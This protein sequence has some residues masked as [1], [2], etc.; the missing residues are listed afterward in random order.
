MQR[1]WSWLQ[2]RR[3][4]PLGPIY[5][6]CKPRD[7]PDY[8]QLPSCWF[9]ADAELHIPQVRWGEIQSQTSN[10][11]HELNVTTNPPPKKNI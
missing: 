6:G 3:S 11:K 2:R 10:P 9:G 4:F 1:F 5:Q 8:S 7:V